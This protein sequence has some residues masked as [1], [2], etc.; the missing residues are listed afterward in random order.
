MATNNLETLRATTHLSLQQA[1]DIIRKQFEFYGMNDKEV[2]AR[3]GA[4]VFNASGFSR[5][6]QHWK[7]DVLV[8]DLGAERSIEATAWGDSGGK[9]FGKFLR[10]YV[11]SGADGFWDAATGHAAQSSGMISIKASLT[12]AQSVISAV[13]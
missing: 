9:K 6:R 13:R 12:V 3:K 8:V 1:Q 7:V 10:T 11:N 2:Q 4:L 5:D